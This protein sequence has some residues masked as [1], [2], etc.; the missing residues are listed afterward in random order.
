M[1]PFS[2]RSFLLLAAAYAVG[3]PASTPEPF[4]VEVL[5]MPTLAETWVG[6]T[7]QFTADALHSDGTVADVTAEATWSSTDEDAATID[8][9]GLATPVATGETTITATLE[10]ISGDA[11]LAVV[12]IDPFGSCKVE[13]A[14]A[15]L[16]VGQASEVRVIWTASDGSTRD[17]SDD[18]EWASSDE[19]VVHV[20]GAGLATAI[21]PGTAEVTAEVDDLECE[22]AMVTVVALA[23]ESLSIGT[24]TGED[25]IAAGQSIQLGA[26]CTTAEGMAFDATD[27][28]E[29]S[30]SPEERPG[31]WTAARPR[32]A[33]DTRTR[34][35]RPPD[36]TASS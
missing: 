32:S 2:L 6:E 26:V 9:H 1:E 21:A 11:T 7:Q 10:R 17:V 33:R 13:P 25:M 30:S 22:P 20:D 15:S 34:T 19:S 16:T 8:D 35:A 5:V 36:R 24:H 31:E 29:W 28:V 23:C 14:S 27:Q 4:V 3:C 12:S 18:A